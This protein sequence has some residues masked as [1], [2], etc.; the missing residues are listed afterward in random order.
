VVSDIGELT[1]KRRI[2]QAQALFT[3]PAWGAYEAE[4]DKAARLASEAPEKIRE[5]MTRELE[6]HKSRLAKLEEQKAS[7]Q[8]NQAGL[9]SRK[10]LLTDNVSRLESERP[11]AAQ[12]VAEQKTVVSDA[13]KRL[14]EARAKVMAE[15]K[16]VEGSGKVGRGQFYRAAKG[17]EEKIQSELQVARERLKGHETRLNTISRGISTAKAELAQIDGSLAN[18]KGEAEI[19]G[20]SPCTQ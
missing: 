5:Q 20:P 9:V 8:S 12:K 13:E 3:L 1:E 11:E 17:D 16:G 7:A 10:Q 19:I 18:L 15:E 4:L 6:A 2:E 14:D